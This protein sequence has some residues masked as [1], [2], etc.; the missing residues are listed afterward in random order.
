MFRL[1]PLTL[2]I[3][4]VSSGFQHL[5]RH[6][7][8]YDA[9]ISQGNFAEFRFIVFRSSSPCSVQASGLLFPD[10]DFLGRKLQDL[11]PEAEALDLLTFF[12]APHAGRLGVCARLARV[13]R[14]ILSVGA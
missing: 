14:P 11:G 13:E 9:A 12:T 6:K 1:F 4:Y 8:I 10:Y 5:H 3:Y 2:R 7:L